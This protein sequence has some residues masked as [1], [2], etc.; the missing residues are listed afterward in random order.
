MEKFKQLGQ[1]LTR[2]DLKQIK[3]GT[4][5]VCSCFSGSSGPLNLYVTSSPVTLAYC[6]SG[7]TRVRCSEIIQ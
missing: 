7:S 1:V 5:Y 3:G 4:E 2:E 6:P